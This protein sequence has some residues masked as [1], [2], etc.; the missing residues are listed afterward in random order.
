MKKI[1]RKQDDFL[2]TNEDGG[3]VSFKVE[4]DP[5]KLYHEESADVFMKLSTGLV[6]WKRNIRLKVT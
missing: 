5:P 4:N 3:R 6:F 1:K 2:S